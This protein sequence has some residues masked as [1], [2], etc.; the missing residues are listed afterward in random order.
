MRFDFSHFEKLT[1]E[2]IKEIEDMINGQI[3]KSLPI[4]CEEMSLDEAKN[5][6][7]MGVFENK[8]GDKVKVYSVGEFSK[9]IC[10][11]PHVKST[12]ELG[13]FKIIKEV[14]PA[15]N[16]R[17]GIIRANQKRKHKFIFII[18]PL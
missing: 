3:Q 6:N 1:K 13:R 7:A 12:G 18:V 17:A 15:K 11:G 8:Y 4:C 14:F 16:N 5:K 9:E 2:Q 10:G